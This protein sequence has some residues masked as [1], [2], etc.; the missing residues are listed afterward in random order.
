MSFSIISQFRILDARSKV[1]YENDNS[2]EGRKEGAIWSKDGR[3]KRLH[4]REV[5]RTTRAIVGGGKFFHYGAYDGS[6]LK[7]VPDLSLAAHAVRDTR[8]IIEGGRKTGDLPGEI[9]WHG[10][11]G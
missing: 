7:R 10:K 4:R 8:G 11:Q 3:E 1:E 5:N 9:G 2:M 6:A